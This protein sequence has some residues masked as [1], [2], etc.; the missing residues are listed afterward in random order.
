MA[1]VRGGL[2]N[3]LLVAIGCGGRD[4]GGEGGGKNES[5]TI[6]AAGVAH[7]GSG[8]VMALDVT[9]TWSE[10]TRTHVRQGSM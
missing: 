6:G 3:V 5:G 4:G 1:V 10:D 2:V 7:L 9:G 8:Y